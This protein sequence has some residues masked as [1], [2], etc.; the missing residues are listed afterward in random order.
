VRLRGLSWLGILIFLFYIWEIDF[1]PS[2]LSE[3][4]GMKRFSRNFDGSKQ[5]ISNWLAIIEVP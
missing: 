2:V 1:S 4:K 3:Q 5:G